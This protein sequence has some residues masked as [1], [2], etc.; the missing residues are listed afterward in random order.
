M[1]RNRDDE[2]TQSI[3]PR[4]GI[5]HFGYARRVH[6]SEGN[7]VTTPNTPLADDD[8]AMGQLIAELGKFGGFDKTKASQLARILLPLIAQ[9][10]AAIRIDELKR[11]AHP[12]PPEY[13]EQRIAELR[14]ESD[15]GQRNQ[16]TG[17]K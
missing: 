9:R 1:E 17:E 13:V 2:R 10:E 5:R 15:L 4:L 11:W 3:Y 7:I 8:T 6:Y 14:R 16:Q 12:W